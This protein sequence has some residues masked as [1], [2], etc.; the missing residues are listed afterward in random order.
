MTHSDWIFLGTAWVGALLVL[1][2]GH[3]YFTARKWTLAERG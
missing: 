1:W 2:L 3:R